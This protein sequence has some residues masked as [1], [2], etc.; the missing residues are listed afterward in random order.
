MKLQQ[1]DLMK[2]E[3]ENIKS[4]GNS[5]QINAILCTIEINRPKLV[6]VCRYKLATGWQNF[7][8]VHTT[9]VKILQKVIG[10]YFYFTH[11]VH[12]I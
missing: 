4:D 11:T 1:F 9:L 12:S 5:R 7:T 8:E 3:T 10:G 6:H 2:L